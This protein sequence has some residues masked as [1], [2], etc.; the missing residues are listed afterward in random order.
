[1]SSNI[2]VL[3]IRQAI[4][5]KEGYSTPA[6]FRLISFI[7]KGF[8]SGA[9]LPVTAT[10]S[11]MTYTSNGAGYLVISGGAVSAVAY[12]SDAVTFYPTG[13]VAGFFPMQVGTQLRITFTV[14]PT[15]NFVPGAA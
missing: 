8:G 9:V 3:D 14:L 6:F 7:R 11:P 10:G 1:M 2:P 13:V 5:D 12:S 4:A 15:L